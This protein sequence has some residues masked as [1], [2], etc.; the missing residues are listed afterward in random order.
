MNAIHFNGNPDPAGG[1]S[2]KSRVSQ[3]EKAPSFGE[4]LKNSFEQVDTDQQKADAAVKS[5]LSGRSDEIHQAMIALEKAD[6]S[7]RFLMQVRN[8]IIAAYETIMRM[9]V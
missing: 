3:Q 4:M 7:F 6:L 5:L 2:P 8:K 1:F 9:Q